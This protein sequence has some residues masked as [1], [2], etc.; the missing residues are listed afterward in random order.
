[1]DLTEQIQAALNSMRPG[2]MNDG[3]DISLVKFE[4]GIVYVRLHGAC[5]TCPVS[6]FHLKIG[7]EYSLK[8][9]IPAVKS[10]IAVE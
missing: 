1:M 7:I 5:I 3:G 8:E 6:T 10:V 9:Q 2:I 4:D